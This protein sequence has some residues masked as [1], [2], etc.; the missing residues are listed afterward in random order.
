MIQHLSPIQVL[1][2]KKYIVN[3]LAK[4]YSAIYTYLLFYYI[5]Y[6]FHMWLWLGLRYQI[7]KRIVLES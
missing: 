7:L 3:H 6:V 2:S 5:N 1:V 4:T